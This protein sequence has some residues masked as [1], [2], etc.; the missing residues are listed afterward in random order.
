MISDIY[1]TV[2]VD[3]AV[4]RMQTQYKSAILV[5]YCNLFPDYSVKACTISYWGKDCIETVITLD[6]GCQIEHSNTNPH[7]FYTT[8][9]K[10]EFTLI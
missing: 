7:L 5:R 6:D 10:S 4:K 8:P 9:S 1:T 3:N 2:Q